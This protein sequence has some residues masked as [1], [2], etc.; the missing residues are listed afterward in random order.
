MFC[1]RRKQQVRRDDETR[2]YAFDPILGFWGIPNLKKRVRFEQRLDVDIEVVHN[3]EG[4]RDTFFKSLDSQGVILCLGGSHTWG[5]GVNQGERYSDLLARRTGRQVI[6]MGHCSFGIDQVALTILQRTKD[7]NPK[8]IVV[9]QYPWAVVRILR[10]C[11]ESGFIKPS[12]FLDVHGQLKL[13][14]VPWIA[15]FGLFRRLIG[16]FNA[17]KKELGDFRGGVDL[18]EGYDPLV[19][20]MFL[21]WK[22]NHYDYL[23]ALLEKIIFVI[24]DYCRQNKIHLLFSLG[25]IRQ[26]FSGPSKSKLIDYDLPRKRLKNI[27]ERSGVS[28]IDVADVMLKEHSENDPVI[29][30][31]GHINVKGHDIFATALQKDLEN[32]GWI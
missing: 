24:R 12:F 32:R 27:L 8:I 11:L 10:N 30:Y 28:Y 5:G 14:K 20:P 9:E 15:R 17:Y 25:A 2:L 19:D 1:K 16:W 6:N 22:T 26:Q 21:H 23:Y 13:R 3:G 31:D 18:K 29:F 4:I 7:Y